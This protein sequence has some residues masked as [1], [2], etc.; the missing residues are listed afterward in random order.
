MNSTAQRQEKAYK[1]EDKA[2]RYTGCLSKIQSLTVKEYTRLNISNTL[3]EFKIYGNLIGLLVELGI[4][5]ENVSSGSRVFH[6]VG[7]LVTEKMV[8]EVMSKLHKFNTRHKVPPINNTLRTSLVPIA[9]SMRNH[10]VQTSRNLTVIAGTAAAIITPMKSRGRKIR[11]GTIKKYQNFL[12]ELWCESSDG[13]FVGSVYDLS[14]KHGIGAVAGKVVQELKIISFPDRIGAG[15]M[16]KCVWISTIPDEKMAHELLNAANRYMSK[17][18]REQ[19]ER[20]HTL[21]KLSTPILSK[22]T[23]VTPSSVITT[24]VTQVQVPLQKSALDFSKEI[25]MKQLKDHLLVIKTKKD[26][27]F[28]ITN[29]LRINID[30]SNKKLT[31]CVEELEKCNAEE[32][33]YTN[34]YLSL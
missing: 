12:E 17:R 3:G 9:G 34:M 21:P 10:T 15:A 22:L 30:I 14:K 4:L 6:W 19:R 32:M 27:L 31:E 23:P 24:P 28:T 16:G 25:F 7:S 20:K 26:D 18:K 1:K 29:T 5:R 8:D 33:K 2:L 13:P 11:S